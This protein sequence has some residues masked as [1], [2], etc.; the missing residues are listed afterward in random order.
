MSIKQHFFL[1]KS[2]KLAKIEKCDHSANQTKNRIRDYHGRVD[3]Q[4][5]SKKKHHVA[6]MA[7]VL[8]PHI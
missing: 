4:N 3:L 5:G 1:I 2:I 6:L 8:A 7:K